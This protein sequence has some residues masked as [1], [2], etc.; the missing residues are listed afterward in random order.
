[1]YTYYKPPKGSDPSFD[2]TFLKHAVNMY[3]YFWSFIF[4]TV[5]FCWSI[6]PSL[7]YVTPFNGIFSFAFCCATLA[8]SYLKKLFI[9]AATLSG[10]IQSPFSKFEV[11]FWISEFKDDK[12]EDLVKI[13]K[14]KVQN[15]IKN[16]LAWI[17]SAELYLT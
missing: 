1:M 16:S 11:R 12:T 5:S 15:R 9:N 8:R 13:S 3:I 4:L 6:D 14:L 2:H 7:Q 17:G 10:C